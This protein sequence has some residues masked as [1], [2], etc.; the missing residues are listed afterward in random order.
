M[1][2]IEIET[3]EQAL[4]LALKLAIQA[5]TDEQHKLATDM[6]ISIAHG[7]SP[8]TVRICKLAAMAAVEYEDTFK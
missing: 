5:P 2:N 4:T 6:A 7:M 1:T 3:S 8:D